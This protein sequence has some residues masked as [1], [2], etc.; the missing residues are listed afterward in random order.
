MFEYLMPTLWFRRYPRTILDDSAH[1]VVRCQ[2]EWVEARSIP[3][4]ISEA[5][6]NLQDAAGQ[7]QYRAFGIPVLAVDPGS[8]KAMVISPYSTF[9]ALSVNPHHAVQNLQ[10]MRGMGWLGTLGFYDS[11]DFDAARVSSPEGY[12]LVTCWMAHHQ[13]MSLLAACNLLSDGFVQ[14]AFH[15]E[16]AVAATELL[17][18]EKPWVV[19]HPLRRANRADAQKT[20]GTT[21]LER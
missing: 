3:W 21:I 6:F 5:A 10:R 14:K 19:T 20:T 12:H 9:L 13:G 7:Y 8:D 15:A 4:G 11:A 2:R 1:V 16:P 18:Q 17:L